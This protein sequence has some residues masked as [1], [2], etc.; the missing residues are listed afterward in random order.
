[1]GRVCCGLIAFLFPYAFMGIFARTRMFNT[2]DGQIGRC[3]FHNFGH[4]IARYCKDFVV[5]IY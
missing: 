4:S 2:S 5:N 1:M 3:G